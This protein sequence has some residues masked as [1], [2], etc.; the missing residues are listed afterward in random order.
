M[1]TNSEPQGGGP[2]RG[3]ET[4][5]G[6]AVIAVLL[7][8]FSVV[9][10]L[11][12]HSEEKPPKVAGKPKPAAAGERPR[13]K[14]ASGPRRPT[15]VS[16][17]QGA[18]ASPAPRA[19]RGEGDAWGNAG[20]AG[21]ES[22]GP[23]AVYIPEPSETDTAD[24]YGGRYAR[25]GGTSAA[26]AQSR[27]ARDDAAA[28]EAVAADA[29]AGEE[30]FAGAAADDESHDAE[31]EEAHLADPF[32]RRSGGALYTGD[33]Y[34]AVPNDNYWTIS[35][36]VYGTG[37]YFKA[38]QEHN[39]DRYPDDGPIHV[40]DAIRVP[41][42]EVLEQT[43]PELCP[44]RRNT[45]PGGPGLLVSTP[46]RAGRRVY[47]VEEGD[48]LFDIARH[49]LGK[50]SRWAEVYELNREQLGDDFDYLAPGMELSLPADTE[51]ADPLASQPGGPLSR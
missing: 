12:L 29:A 15:V 35:E 45:R 14:L 26:G 11:R 28:G 36:K 49:E 9:L 37:A 20:D 42:Q 27:Y 10:I 44:K 3:R 2:G 23:P 17:K 22:A 47:T 19:S 43:Y 13:A 1:D 8:V 25:T 46:R 5:I 41:A 38:I 40:G 18:G 51:E 34:V 6:L 4:K 50:A 24:R 21:P 16:A 30:Q 7:G 48:T 31:D 33:S 39:R 32:R